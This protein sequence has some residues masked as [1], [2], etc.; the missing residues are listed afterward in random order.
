MDKKQMCV[1]GDDTPVTGGIDL[2]MQLTMQLPVDDDAPTDDLGQQ[3]YW[4]LKL[5]AGKIALKFRQSDLSAM[6]DFT[7]QQL[8]ADIQESL[9]VK[10]FKKAMI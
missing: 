6:D 10:P 5:N 3:A 7:K 8:I 4:L 2:P 1:N 9:G